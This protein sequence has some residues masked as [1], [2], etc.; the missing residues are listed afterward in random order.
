MK[1][2]PLH[3]PPPLPPQITVERID[4]GIRYRLPPRDLGLV[5]T[6]GR[7]MMI[8]GLLLILGT[9]IYHWPLL[10][11]LATGNAPNAAQVA[12]LVFALIFPLG[13]LGMVSLGRRLSG[14]RNEI[15]VDD[16]GLLA[17]GRPRGP[18]SRRRVKLDHIHRF[19]LDSLSR[20]PLPDSLRRLG[21]LTVQAEASMGQQTKTLLAWG[22]PVPWLEA[23]AYQLAADLGGVGSRPPLGRTLPVV[24]EAAEADTAETRGLLHP[25][26][27]TTGGLRTDTA[28]SGSA[29]PQP[30]HLPDQPAKSNAVV[31]TT[32]DGVTVSL[33][34]RGL[35]RGSGGLFPFSL[36]WLG[37][38]CVFTPPWFLG[39]GGG[40]VGGSILPALGLLA[41]LALFWGIGFFML[42]TAINLGRR[43][44]TLA[45]VGSHLIIEQKSLLG[46]R[47]SEWTA[48][49]LEAIRVGPSG[50]SSNDTPLMN[51]HI[52]PRQGSPAK[53]FMGRSEPELHWL[54]ALLRHHLTQAPR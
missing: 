19:T 31:E 26:Q 52:V 7:L 18:G 9:L 1:T 12:S 27:T 16:R 13:G 11:T 22:Y 10:T 42:A 40:A 37:F 38:M 47:T 39:S 17:V 35:W 23:L 29:Q 48:D 45:I 32:R 51:L 25:G 21:A 4:R 20:T 54:A 44:A 14:G 50:V 8:A 28:T 49:D 53:L 41:F 46:T 34:P 6:L 3:L 15:T 43:H 36:F 24:F 33:P 2:T 5:R 30:E